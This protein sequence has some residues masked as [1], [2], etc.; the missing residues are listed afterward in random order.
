MKQNNISC[1]PFYSLPLVGK[2]NGV[3]KKVE[4]IIFIF[5]NFSGLNFAYLKS[6]IEELIFLNTYP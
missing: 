2:G 5:F 6:V 3:E 4:R 1:F